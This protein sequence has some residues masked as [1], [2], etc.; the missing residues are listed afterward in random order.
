[1]SPNTFPDYSLS[2]GMEVDR[3]SMSIEEP[4]GSKPLENENRSLILISLTI[5]NLIS[6]EEVEGVKYGL[7]DRNHHGN[8]SIDCNI[9]S[10]IEDLVTSYR[11][12]LTK[13]PL[14]IFCGNHVGLKNTLPNPIL[15][16]REDMME[17]VSSSKNQDLRI[18]K[19]RKG[20]CREG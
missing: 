20:W 16:T 8:V 2:K 15:D 9:D 14:P 19:V 3:K 4:I 17:N 11:D 13:S 5:P 6:N 7:D 1:M 12:V 10:L 18:G